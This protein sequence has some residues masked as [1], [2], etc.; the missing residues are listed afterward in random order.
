MEIIH[1]LSFGFG[2]ALSP[3][4]VLYCFGG[5]FIGTFVGVLPGIGPTTAIS[6]L[7]PITFKMSPIGALTMLAGIYYG[8]HH[9]GSTTAIML[10]MPGEPSS[11]VIC[12]DGHPLARE[13]RAGSAL[14]I[15]A[16]GSF[17][18][19]SVGVV[20]IAGLSPLLAKAALD[21]G[22]PE[23][24]A[25]IVMALV[26]ASVLSAD[27]LV[28]NTAMAV[29]GLLIGVVGTDLNTGVMRFT[30]G[31]M[32][33]ADGVSFVAV[34]VGLFA[35]AE[36]ITQMGKLS[37][38]MPMTAKIKSLWPERQDLGAAWRPALRGTALGA[39]LGVFPGIG[40]LVSSF[41]S[42]AMERRL[43][44]NS[45]R[46]GN[47]AIE[48]V[49]GPEAANN[50]SAITHFIP[51]LTLGLPA[52][53]PMALMLAA[54]E[55]QGIPPGPQVM[56]AHPDLFWGVVASMW[57]GNAM[58]LVLNLPLIG[59]WVRLL[60]IPYRLLFPAILAFCC[61]GV[62]STNNL[63]FD[64]VLAA[65]FGV[66][67]T[68]FKQLGCHPAPLVLGLVLEPV[69]E[70]NF[71]RALILSHGDPTVFVTHPICLAL[72]ALTAI[73]VVFFHARGAFAKAAAV[74]VSGASED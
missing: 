36:T 49:A 74:S 58:L 40:P 27:S 60:M 7:L 31:R 18:A 23:Y 38:R 3:I 54:M 24:V 71:R 17:F 44:H 26:T 35:F 68:V 12:I 42:Y 62:Y 64:I 30:F 33:L 21:L 19:G 25:M 8:S 41:A 56:T 73:L 70:G 29:L 48:G 15:A 11:V 6:M 5:A 2:V 9:A 57:I 14:C 51:M 13:G 37:D 16:L 69:L 39:A 46:F 4:N 55:I 53:A 63:P 34:A 52:G 67:G 28:L 47:G 61:I 43:A 10:N 22:A 50:A 45:A 72:F 20:V 59:V 32:E 65:L 66:A 1:N